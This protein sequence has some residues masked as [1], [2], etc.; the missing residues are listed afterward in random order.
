MGALRRSLL[1]LSLSI[2]TAWA[3]SFVSTTVSSTAAAV[4]TGQVYPAVNFTTLDIYVY[5]RPLVVNGSSCVTS[6]TPYIQRVSYYVYEGWAIVD[7]D[8]IFGREADIL[9][10]AVGENGT[11]P[12]RR[13]LQERSLSIQPMSADK[14]ANGEVLYDWAPGLSD[15]AKTKF[16]DGA[17]MWTDRLPFLKFTLKSKATD[18]KVRVIREVPG[19]VSSSPVGC[20]GMEILLGEWATA[21]TAAHEIGH[22]LGLRHEQKRGDRDWHINV[23]CEEIIDPRTCESDPRLWT[24]WAAQYA[25]IDSPAWDYAGAYDVDSI[26]HYDARILARGSKPVITGRPGIFFKDSGRDV[27]TLADSRHVCELY[28]EHCHAICGDGVLSPEFE[29]CDDGNN[30]DGDGCPSNCKG[31]PPGNCLTTCT[32][33]ALP[34]AADACAWGA[35]RATCEIFN[36]GGVTPHSGQA[37]CF[38]QAGYRADGVDPTNTQL[39]YHLQWDNAAGGQTHRVAV[40]PGQTCNTP[41]SDNLCSEVPLRSE[42]L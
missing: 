36:S 34:P 18:P 17:K 21:S 1:L 2:T 42:C 30:L 15:A 29:T 12:S 37:F 24:G 20:C 8:V 38:C 3:Q 25:I 26:M 14:W 13:D 32:P 4:P 22:T 6:Q 33:A 19:G 31:T 16:L 9:A 39:Q 10:V 40:R 28:W 35:G 41:C 11:V 23:D 5:P 7:G 27:P